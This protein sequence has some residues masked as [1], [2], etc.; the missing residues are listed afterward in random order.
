M[1]SIGAEIGI[2]C[3][4]LPIFVFSN[5]RKVKV[6]FICNNDPYAKGNGLCTAVKLT[7]KHLRERGVETRLVS[8][9]S[10]SHD[11]PQPE[12]PL[13]RFIFPVFQPLID[14]NC[15][16]FAKLDKAVVSEAVA[17]ADVIHIEEPFPVQIYAIKEAERMGKPIVASFHMFTDNIFYNVRMGWC[18]FGNRMLMNFWKKHVYDHCSHIHCPSKTVEDLLGSYGFKADLRAFSNGVIV[19]PD[20]LENTAAPKAPYQILSIGRFSPEKNQILL[21]KAMRYSRHSKEIQL[22]FAGF[23]NLLKSFEKEGDK[24]LADGVLNY[25]PHFG[26][27]KFE[28]L[29]K[30]I[31]ESYLYYHGAVVEVEGLSC[32][33]ALRGGAV[34]VIAD[35]PL[36]ATKDFALVPESLF[37]SGDPQDLARK[38]DWWIEHPDE[39]AEYVGR[40]AALVSKY[41]IQS[42]IDSMIEMYSDAIRSARK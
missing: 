12:Y 23:G 38:I 39:H 15:F 33:E 41:N 19:R 17:W 1:I 36:A 35:A 34:P 8:M 26:F 9:V 24:L 6:L 22:S 31:S 18:G 25:R 30:I 7:I 10:P 28:H 13:Q 29:S 37:K 3:K 5:H 16:C 11:G 27:Y 2:N 32:L 4:I 20:R 14:A 21:L 40:Y 42:S